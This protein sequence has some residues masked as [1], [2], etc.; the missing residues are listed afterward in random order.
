MPRRYRNVSRF[1]GGFVMGRPLGKKGLALPPKKTRGKKTR[2]QRMREIA[3]E[4]GPTVVAA[5]RSRARGRG[6]SAVARNSN[7]PSAVPTTVITSDNGTLTT[8]RFYKKGRK[9]NAILRGNPATRL[10]TAERRVVLG[11]EDFDVQ[12]YSGR[13]CFYHFDRLSNL[14]DPRSVYPANQSVDLFN[15]ISTFDAGTDFSYPGFKV[16]DTYFSLNNIKTCLDF[17]NTSNTKVVVKIHELVAKRDIPNVNYVASAV[18]L[19]SFANPTNAI[20]GGIK[21]RNVALTETPVFTTTDFRLIT[22]MNVYANNSHL[23]NHYYKIRKTTTVKLSAGCSHRHWSTLKMNYMPNILDLTHIADEDEN[24]STLGGFDITNAALST[25]AFAQ[26][27]I[28]QPLLLEI[29]SSPQV[30]TM[31]DAVNY[32]PVAI[33][34]HFRNQISYSYTENRNRIARYISDLET[35]N[36]QSEFRIFTNQVE[37]AIDSTND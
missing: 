11:T 28:Y 7:K 14:E 23:F 2:L 30:V 6:R 31:G 24:L 13:K 10:I 26:S 27:G 5:L 12:T 21:A 1:R 22:H 37:Q 15:L 19:H 20:S 29:S 35:T 18:N 16:L 25:G 32:P 17:T 36:A 4:Y 34:C 33:A 9:T 8:S 3:E